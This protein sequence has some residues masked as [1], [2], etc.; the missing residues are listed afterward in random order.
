M[1]VKGKTAT[2]KKSKVKKKAQVLARYKV[3]TISRAQGKLTFAKVSGSK[4]LSINKST[5][6]VTVK[7]KTKKGTQSMKVRVTAAGN[8]NYKAV[9][10]IVTV[11]V[12]VK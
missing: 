8:G 6:K 5:G 4:K 2:V 1:V 11:K 12:K 3:L 7:K 10:K 9:S